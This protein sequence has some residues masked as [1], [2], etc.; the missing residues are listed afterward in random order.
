MTKTR[1]SLIIFAAAIIFG[2][3]FFLTRKSEIP[4]NNY[5]KIGVIAPLT[6]NF[7][8]FGER[9]R[10]AMELALE[11]ISIGKEVKI[12]YEDACSP[13]EAVSAAKKLIEVDKVSWLGGSFCLVGFVP[14][15]T[16]T[17]ENKMIAFNTAPNPDSILNH[18]YVF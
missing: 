11:D 14:I 8:I 4:N 1:V 6:G 16:L 15:I 17:E 13:K 18:P 7:S 2:F 9:I 3:G 10:N 5:V 12:I